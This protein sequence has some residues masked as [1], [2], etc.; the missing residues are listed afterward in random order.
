MLKKILI[1][2]GVIFALIAAFVIY[3]V[4][5]SGSKSPKETVNFDNGTVAVDVV[6]GRPYKKDRLIF[7]KQSAG[8]LVPFG[9]Y[10]RLGA[11]SSTE[12]SFTKD[13]TFAGAPIKAGTYRIYAMPDASQWQ[14]TLNSETDTFGYFE[15]DQTRDVATVKVP[16]KNDANEVEQFTITVS[17]IDGALLVNFIWD[18]TVVSAP[19]VVQ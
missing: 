17:E 14:I 10:W 6:Y 2:V 5:T 12:I 4:M 18:T 15:P 8:A 1:G 13:V 3:T 11:N 7:G 16:V 9:K 19:I